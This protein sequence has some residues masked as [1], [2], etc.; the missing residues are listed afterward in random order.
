MENAQKQ[1]TEEDLLFAEK[2]SQF[3]YKN[4][5]KDTVPELVL[6]GGNFR[7]VMEN[8]IEIGKSLLKI[9]EITLFEWTDG[10]DHRRDKVDT[11]NDGTLHFDSFDFGQKTDSAWGHDYEYDIFVGAEW[12]DTILLLLIKERFKNNSEFREWADKKTVPYTTSCY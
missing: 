6:A 3:V 1:Y 4:S 9:N 2:G 7:G 5:Y 12:K 10:K 11:N 8:L